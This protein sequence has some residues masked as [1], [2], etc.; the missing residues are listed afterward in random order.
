MVAKPGGL[1]NNEIVQIGSNRYGDI[2]PDVKR[3]EKV[4]ARYLAGGSILSKLKAVYNGEGV[5]VGE[6][7]RR[8]LDY[9]APSKDK[10][11]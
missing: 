9:G 8:T 7:P 2:A 5:R 3:V 4:K 1:G 11:P 10:N 6:T